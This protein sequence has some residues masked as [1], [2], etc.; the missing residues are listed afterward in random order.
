MKYSVH[1]GISK[2]KFRGQRRYD[3][4]KFEPYILTIFYFEYINED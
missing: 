2:K 3:K 4:L 1:G